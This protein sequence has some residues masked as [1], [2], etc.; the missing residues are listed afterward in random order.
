MYDT[1][2]QLYW[3]GS[4]WQSGSS[5][6]TPD[7]ELNDWSYTLELPVDGQ[8]RVTAWTWDLSNNLSPA[9]TRQFSGLSDD[10][11]PVVEITS[12]NVVALNPDAKRL[13]IGGSSTDNVSVDR[14]ILLIYD[15]T[16]QLYWNGSAWQSG[17]SFF[18]P[19]NEL[20]HWSYT[21]DLPVDGLY[22]V[23]AW[24]FD[25]SNN[26]SNGTSRQIR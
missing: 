6:V 14:N 17:A 2:R 23:T 26:L 4:A 24:A 18:S 22:R 5:F 9:A 11:L 20:R 25:S 12:I 19:G 7:N 10:V 13:T 16:R 15:S 1:T 21:L 8:Y 3:N